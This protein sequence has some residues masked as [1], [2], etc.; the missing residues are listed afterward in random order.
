ML[1]SKDIKYPRIKRTRVVKITM[2]KKFSCMGII[3]TQRL[4]DDIGVPVVPQWV[5]NPTYC[6]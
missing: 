2:K 4:K 5:K 1:I 6:P 3:R